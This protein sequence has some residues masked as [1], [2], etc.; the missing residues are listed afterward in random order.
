MLGNTP[1][2]TG[3]ATI[4]LQKLLRVLHRGEIATPLSLPELTRCGL[5]HC[6]DGLMGGLRGCDEAGLRA[7]L[8]CVLAERT[9]AGRRMVGLTDARRQAR[10]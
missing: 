5:Q 9:D 6:A 2:L 8:V 3:V 4:D 10:G 7:V 1:G